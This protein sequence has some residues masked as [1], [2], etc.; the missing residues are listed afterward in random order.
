[1]KK[2]LFADCPMTQHYNALE[3]TLIMYPNFSVSAAFRCG[4]VDNIYLI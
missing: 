3:S 4:A 2:I 1:M